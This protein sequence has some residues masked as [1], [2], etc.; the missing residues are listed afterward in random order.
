MCVRIYFHTYVDATSVTYQK[1]NTQRR[2]LRYYISNRLNVL[3]F[4]H[5]STLEH[6]HPSTGR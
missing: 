1:N 5:Q 6:G 2:K 3:T 4:I